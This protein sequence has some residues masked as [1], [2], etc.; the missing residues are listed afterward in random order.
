MILDQQFVAHLYAPTDGPD[1]TAAYRRLKEIWR[2]CALLLRMTEPVPGTGLPPVPPDHL[3]DVVLEGEGAVAALERAGADCQAI[4]RRHHDL[5]TLSVALAPPEARLPAD[6]ATGTRWPWWRTQDY[7]WDTL[8]AE[9]LPLMIGE[10]RLHLTRVDAE[11]GIR[12]AAAELRQ[13]LHALLPETAEG[14]PGPQPGVV[15]PDGAAALWEHPAAPDERARR[16]F[17]LAIRPDADPVASAWVW[18]NGDTG[19]PPLARYLAHAAK[20]RYQLRVWRRD[21]Q[22]RQLRD[23]IDRLGSQLRALGAGG[24]AEADLLRLRRFDAL[25]LRTGLQEMHRTVEIAADNLTRAFDLEGMLTPGGPF[26]D[27]AALARSFLERLD[28]QLAYL[29]VAAERAA[30]ASASGV[31]PA[32]GQSLEPAAGRPPAIRPIPT[33]GPAPW[34]EASAEVLC[35][36][37]LSTGTEEADPASNVF[38]VYG[39]DEPARRAVF[40]F[41]RTIGLNPLEWEEVV[42]RTGKATPTLGEAVARA[43]PLARAVVVLLTPDDIVHL[44]PGLHGPKE[45]RAERE[46]GLQARPN[47]LLELGMAL[48]FQPSRTVL[49]QFGELRPATDLGGLNYITVTDTPDFRA[50]LASRLELAG[51]RVRY[52]GQDWLSAGD[53]GALHAYDRAPALPQDDALALPPELPGGGPEVVRKRT[54]S[55]G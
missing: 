45:P 5:L 33:R 18:S 47:V 10:A 26:A 4:L 25:L 23:S 9:H 28:D 29:T 21:D 2:G 50:K 52:V 1:A 35:E 6:G 44:H 54:G 30:L 3:D 53:F 31:P 8:V 40:D 32:T 46:P 14:L 11:A 34:P 55:G 51:C 22:A 37:G 27:D 38:V 49:L 39:R 19:I 43:I 41:L 17:V 12:A 7:Q 16:R 48:A 13:S 20:L 15:L 42:R 24:G 36:P